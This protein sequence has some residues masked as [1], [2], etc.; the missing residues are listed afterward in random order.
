MFDKERWRWFTK[1]EGMADL[2]IWLFPI[3]ITVAVFW[4]LS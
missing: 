1:P 3:A 4:W 2:L